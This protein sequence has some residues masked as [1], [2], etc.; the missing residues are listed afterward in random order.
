MTVLTKLGLQT[1]LVW[2]LGAKNFVLEPPAQRPVTGVFRPLST[3]KPK[4]RMEMIPLV[5][6]ALLKQNQRMSYSK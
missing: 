4:V 6:L 3:R 1:H 5:P 2:N